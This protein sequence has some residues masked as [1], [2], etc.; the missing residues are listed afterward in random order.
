M[1][2]IAM[3]GY[4]FNKEAP[5]GPLTPITITKEFTDHARDS[6]VFFMRSNTIS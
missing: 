3:R 6:G 1:A 5:R 2:I 4:D